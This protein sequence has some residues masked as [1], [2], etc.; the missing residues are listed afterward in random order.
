MLNARRGDIFMDNNEGN[1]LR[2]NMM[3]EPVLHRNAIL[4]DSFNFEPE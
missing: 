2:L 3:A 1:E 4:V